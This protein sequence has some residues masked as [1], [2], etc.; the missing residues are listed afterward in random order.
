M[1]V[2]IEN[3]VDLIQTEQIL[4]WLSQSG[5]WQA[6]LLYMTDLQRVHRFIPSF[7]TLQLAHT[8]CKEGIDL[9]SYA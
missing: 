3:V 5:F 2:I 9:K 8:G 6:M 4:L 7:I 1:K